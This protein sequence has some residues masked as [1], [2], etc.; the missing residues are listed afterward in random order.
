MW[1]DGWGEC[2]KLIWEMVIILAF[3]GLVLWACPFSG[4]PLPW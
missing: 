2:M 4:A 3:V 1:C